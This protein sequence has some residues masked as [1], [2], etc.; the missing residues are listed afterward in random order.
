VKDKDKVK[1]GKTGA[2][3]R[4]SVL[5]LVRCSFLG[6]C[7]CV[8]F[9]VVCVFIVCVCALGLAG[10]PEKEKEKDRDGPGGTHVCFRVVLLFL[11]SLL[12]V[13]ECVWCVIRFSLCVCV[14]V[15]V[16]M[17]V[18][19]RVACQGQ[20]QRQRT[21][22]GY[23]RSYCVLQFLICVCFCC[24]FVDESADNSAELEVVVSAKPSCLFM[25]FAFC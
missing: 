25:R 16:C 2:Y 24:F 20:R 4:F 23:G 13:C 11:C 7:D 21:T 18:F 3:V 17:C 22:S 6:A 8:A 12:S 9:Y 1:D 10:S 14:R 19:C 5:L 15:C